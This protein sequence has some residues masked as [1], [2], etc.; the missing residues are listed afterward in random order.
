MHAKMIQVAA[1]AA[2]V[3]LGA[4]AVPASAQSSLTISGIADVGVQHGPAFDG[5]RSTRVAAGFKSSRLIFSGTEDMGGGTRANFRFE[6]GISLDTGAWSNFGAFHRAS[7]LGMSNPGWGS[8]RLGK[9][10]APTAKLVCVMADLFDCG[11]GFNNSGIFYNGTNA[12]GRW[13]SVKPGRGGNANAGMSSF[14]GGGNGLPNNSDSGRVANA[15]FYDSPSWGGFQVGMVYAMGEVPSTNSNKGTHLGASLAYRSGP[16]HVGISME[17][18]ES[19]PLWDAK[20]KL[21]SVAGQYAVTKELR[22]SGIYQS[23]K[24]SGPRALWT[25]ASAWM[26]GAAYDMGALEPFVRVGGH[27]TNGVGAFNIVNGKDAKVVDIGV[28]YSFSKR[29]TGYLEYTTDRAGS[30][31][32]GLNRKDPNQLQVGVTHTF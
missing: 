10:L 28:L 4:T 2:A 13:V 12:F 31:A 16:I 22:V 11:G 24:A 29:T 25:D 26:V 14:S 9:A 5:V 30:N 21:I 7:W 1:A 6:A 32:P 3:V 27:R 20:G 15:I 8:V 17:S 23:E 18:T 19:D